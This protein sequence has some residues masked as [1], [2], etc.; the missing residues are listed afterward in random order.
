MSIAT[1]VEAPVR[2]LVLYL[3]PNPGDRVELVSAEAIGSLDGADVRLWFSPAIHEGNGDTVVGQQLDPLAGASFVGTAGD[4]TAGDGTAGDGSGP[5]NTVGLVAELTPHR[6]G[7]FTMT[8]VRV[9]LR[10]NG[11]A[12][13][14]R[15]GVSVVT[16][17]CAGTPAPTDCP[18][19]PE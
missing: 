6:S 16:Y 10:I 18:P 1:A 19:R 5:G 12:E 11:G 9:R 7:L 14:E 13:L 3:Q 2:N 4:G 17:V 15:A 8:N